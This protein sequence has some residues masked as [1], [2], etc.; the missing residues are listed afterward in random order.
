LEILDFSAF[1]WY[2]LS[3]EKMMKSL[4]NEELIEYAKRLEAEVVRKQIELEKKQSEYE[5]MQSNYEKKQSDFEKLQKEHDRLSENFEKLRKLLF[6][7][8]SE[9][10]R[11]IEDADQLSFVARIFNEAEVF[12]KDAEKEELSEIQIPGHAR[13]KKRTREELIA[14][15]PAFEV[16]CDTEEEDQVCGAC[17]SKTRYLGKEHVRDEIEM[18]PQKMHILRYV[19]ANYVCDECHKE[20]NQARIIKSKVPEPVIKHS[21]AS[22]SAVAHVI[23]QKYVNAMPLAR[24]EKDWSYQGVN[25]GRATLGNWI[26]KSTRE[27]LI[28]LYERM[29]EDLLQ[30]AVIAADETEIQVLKEKDKA[31]SSKSKMWVYRSIDRENSPP[32]VLFEYQ[33]GR[34][35]SYAASFLK[36]F[37]GSLMT[38]GYQG[39]NSVAGVN[40]CLCWAHARRYWHQALP[41]DTEGSKAK[42]GLDYCNDLFLL[43]KE[44]VGLSSAERYMERNKRAKPILDKYFAWVESLDVLAGSNLGK[45]AQYSLNNKVGLLG[46]LKDG[47]TEISNNRIE[48]NIRKFVIGRNNFIAVDTVTGAKASAICY[49]LV[50]SAQENGLNVYEYLKYLFQELPKRRK[51]RDELILE[52]CLPWSKALPKECYMKKDHEGD[53]P[54]Q[55]KLSGM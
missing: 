18:I 38:D 15:L 25:V 53:G 42:T 24:Q 41:K 16:L 9:K 45:A 35:G 55:L 50:I 26:L 12:A 22:P 4:T 54:E 31:P 10:R 8:S 43:E 7:Q 34:S 52:N 6:G 2:N 11:F 21:L 3:M 28:P 20:E 30:G 5:K 23:Y 49:S 40:H 37:T 44:W 32:L 33:P 17:G 19:R 46:Y 13:K 48:G 14:T 36:G 47:K 29:K 27:H 51:H 1:F 39:Y